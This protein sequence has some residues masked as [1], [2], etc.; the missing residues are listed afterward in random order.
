MCLI[1]F[2]SHHSSHCYDLSSPYQPPVPYTKTILILLHFLKQSHR[3]SSLRFE[4][5]CF[6]I[7]MLH[8]SFSCSSLT[9]RIHGSLSYSQFAPSGLCY[10]NLRPKTDRSIVPASITLWVQSRPPFLT[11]LC[12]TCTKT[13]RTEKLVAVAPISSVSSNPTGGFSEVTGPRWE[14]WPSTSYSVNA[15]A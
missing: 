13:L 4:V 5:D 1:S 11:G 8:E 10:S 7:V 15:F 3:T 12:L 2:H 9:I 14:R 6:L